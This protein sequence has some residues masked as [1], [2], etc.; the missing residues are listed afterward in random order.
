M[1]ETWQRRLALALAVAAFAIAAT[2]LI[3]A[4]E[5][6]GGEPVP[7]PATAA[8]PA[9]APA[10]ID[11][12]A[13]VRRLDAT[14]VEISRAAFD[15]LIADPS[16]VAARAEQV[17]GGFRVSGIGRGSVLDR[18]GLRDGDVI[19]GVDGMDVSTPAAALEVYQQLRS[20]N[21]L[22]IDLYRDAEPVQISVT[23]R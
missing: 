13:G 19:R 6:R 10:K 15:A 17:A 21:R 9:P 4:I 20:A 7:A 14:H 22:T 18:A 8:A 11:P 2:A 12:A 16:Q 3:V 23:I 5:R 1:S